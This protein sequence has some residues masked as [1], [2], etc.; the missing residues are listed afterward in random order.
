MRKLIPSV[1]IVVLCFAALTG[2]SSKS[3]DINKDTTVI[4][5]PARDG[6]I[7]EGGGPGG[8]GGGAASQGP[9]KGKKMPP[10]AK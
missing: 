3:I 6:N 9:M 8:G 7:K 1:V 2:C 4:F 5:D 10:P